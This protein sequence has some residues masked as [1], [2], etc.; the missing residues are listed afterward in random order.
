MLSDGEEY[1][2]E[3]EDFSI[4]ESELSDRGEDRESLVIDNLSPNTKV[5]YKEVDTESF[6]S[7]T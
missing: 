7:R 1:R 6:R 2:E 5:T 3:R 4:S